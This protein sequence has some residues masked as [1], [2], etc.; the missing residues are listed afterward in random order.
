LA[1]SPR[2]VAYQALLANEK[3]P[4]Q[5]IDDILSKLLQQ[6][7]LNDQEKRWV[8]ELVY[9]TTRMKLQLDSF[10]IPVFKG[11]Y[12]KAQHSIKTLLRMGTFQLKHMQTSEHA[13]INET[14]D[15]SKK[16]KQGRA[17][18]LINA[19]LR[20]IQKIEL[21]DILHTSESEIRKRSIRASHPEWLIQKWMERYTPEEV[22]ALCLHN[23]S[24]PQ[25]WVRRNSLAVSR[26]DFEAFLK[27]LGIEF[28]R[29]ELLDVFYEIK[30]AGPL[31]STR[32]FHDGWFSFQDLAAGIVAT[33]LEPNPQEDIL[34][35]CSAPGGKMAFLA[36]LSGGQARITACDASNLRLVKVRENIERL[37]LK[38]IDVITSDAGV[39]ELPESDKILLD[40][41]CSGTGVLNRRPDAR[42]KRQEADI[43]SLTSI[44]SDILRNTWK[45]LR[46][47]GL[48]VYATC[49]LEPEENWDL[50]NDVL[51]QL[52]GAR[53]EVIKDDLLKPYIDEKGALSTLPWRDGMD[54]MFAVKIR[55]SL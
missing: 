23:N 27:D 18:G 14:V 35:A 1:R 29:S 20:K 40:V 11:R 46:P 9:G 19:V 15:L 54:G 41:P 7:E 36:E 2:E 3:D 31:F 17:S 25:T 6:S 22:T 13:A 44:Q 30:G 50:I 26:D 33:L 4:T 48:L 39:A 5:G 34:D 53:V 16:V 52:E 8:M 51:E 42:W 37:Q 49:T 24:V 38:G 43:R 10:I 32:Q 47:G 55:K 21:K 45:Y 28:R 12:K